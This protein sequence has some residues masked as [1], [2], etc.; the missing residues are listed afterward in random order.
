MSDFNYIE[1]LKNNPLKE[2]KTQSTKL[3]TEAQEMPKEAKMTKTQLKEK[4]REEIL[5]ALNEEEIEEMPLDEAFMN[6][7]IGDV[8]DKIEL[9]IW[10]GDT[11]KWQDYLNKFDG[12][13]K[14]INAASG[15]VQANA[16]AYITPVTAVTAA[17]V[18]DVM[19]AIYA[20]IPVDIINKPDLKIFIGEDISRLYITALTNANLFHFM[21]TD[22]SLGEYK[23]HGTNVGVIPVPGLNGQKAAYALRTSN[24]FLGVDLEGEDEEVK[25]WY[26]ED[27]DQVMIRLKFKMGVQISQTSEIVKFTW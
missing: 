25:A 26:S 1:Y 10:Q 19:Q 15:P 5:S 17:N 2:T 18:I 20:A 12:L 13:V 22:N 21:P 23:L 4:I 3:I 11:A 24:M 8:K 14:I 27:Y 7:V 6:T 9:A 16:A